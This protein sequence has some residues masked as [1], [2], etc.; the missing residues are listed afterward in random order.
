MFAWLLLR[1]RHNTKDLIHRRHWNV[2][3]ENHC[4]LCTLRAHE[5]RIH[6]FFECNFSQHIWNYLQIE[7]AGNDDLQSSISAARRSFGKPFF[8]EV[9]I[10][11]CRQIWLI[12]N[13]KIFHNETPTFA[14][15][16]CKFIHSISLLKHRIKQKH[17]DSFSSWI[18]S[19]P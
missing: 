7:W 4:V 2:T 14:K 15:W 13:A 5:D 12:R 19:L 17:L 8:M 11:A 18:T 9:V 16:K 10:M 1:D 6:L 3:D